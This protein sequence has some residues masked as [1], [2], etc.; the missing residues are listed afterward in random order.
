M[1]T[2]ATPALAGTV[3][4]EAGNAFSAPE[5][6]L[7]VFDD[8]LVGVGA[9]LRLSTFILWQGTLELRVGYAVGLTQNG[10][11][12][13]NPNTAYVLLSTNL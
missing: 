2:P 8:T 6:L 3:F 4:A 10:Y 11:W 9:E 7:D 12:F 1:A 13:D 5:S